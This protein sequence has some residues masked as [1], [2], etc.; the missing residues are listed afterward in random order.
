[1]PICS[2]EAAAAIWQAGVAAVDPRLLVRDF[3]RGHLAPAY[4]CES[5]ESVLVLGAGK[6]GRAMVEGLQEG[7]PPHMTQRGLVLV[8]QGGE[9]QFGQVEVRAVRPAGINLPT[10]EAMRGTLAMLDLAAACQAHERIVV[11]VSGGGS[12]ITPAPVAGV[13]LEEKI[14]TTRLLA[15]AGADIVQLNTVRKHLSRFKGGGLIARIG[16]SPL[17]IEARNAGSHP[18]GQTVPKVSALIISDVV[19]DPLETIGSGPT[20]ADPSTFADSVACGRDLGVWDK[21]PESVRRYLERG[22]R[23]ESNETLKSLPGWVENAVLGSN[24]IALSAAQSEARKR[25]W[26]TLNLG[27]FFE[28][29]TRALAAFHLALIRSI[30][31][32]EPQEPPLCLLSGGETTVKLGPDPRPGGRNQEFA[33]TLLR[34]LHPDEAGGLCLLAAGT[35]GE[36]GPTNAAGGFVDAQ[37]KAIWQRRWGQDRPRMQA[38]VD[39]FDNHALL[40]ELDALFSPGATGTNVMDLRVALIGGSEP[41]GSSQ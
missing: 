34:Q 35:D 41:P 25:G 32:G 18:V 6:A 22:L 8:P 36:D 29:D 12:A 28:G 15:Q 26:K 5:V 14:A 20:V 30:R 17:G 24:R 37:A 11:L 7:L 3:A 19:G 40:G 4:E 23:G 38:R 10:A 16:Q 1:M 31:R 13:T 9:G 21:L 2:R 39:C 27:S 33:L